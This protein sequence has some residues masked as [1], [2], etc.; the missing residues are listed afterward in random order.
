[1][2]PEA[3]AGAAACLGAQAGSASPRHVG[4]CARAWVDLAPLALQA[5]RKPTQ[6]SHQSVLGIL[7]SLGEVVGAELDDRTI[8]SRCLGR[9]HG[10]NE[11]HQAH[12]LHP[13]IQEEEE[14]Q[15]TGNNTAGNNANVSSPAGDWGGDCAAAGV[16][17]QAEMSTHLTEQ[18]SPPAFSQAQL[19]P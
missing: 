17:T 7:Q 5:P 18:L 6:I 11:G 16:A 19:P 14:E 15:Q 13:E 9:R 4:A 1:M 3:A 10:Q 2:R 8:C 12:D